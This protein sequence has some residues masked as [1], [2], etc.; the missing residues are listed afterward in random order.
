[1]S[2]TTISFRTDRETKEEAMR[3][4]SELGLDMSTALNM[5]LRQAL[6][7]NGIPFTPRRENPASARARYEAENGLGE[8]FITFDELTADLTH[9]S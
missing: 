7:D 2:T 8:K 6:V 1:M 9:A 5:F 4:F 3:L